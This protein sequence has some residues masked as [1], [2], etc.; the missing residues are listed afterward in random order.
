MIDGHHTLHSYWHNVYDSIQ[1]HI[2]LLIFFFFFLLIFS[3]FY[4]LF[5]ILNVLNLLFIPSLAFVV[6]RGR[7][8][9]RHPQQLDH[10]RQDHTEAAIVSL[11]LALTVW[12]TSINGTRL[13]GLRRTPHLRLRALH[14]V[15]QCRSKVARVFPLMEVDGDRQMMMMMMMMKHRISAFSKVML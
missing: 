10:H 9:H 13:L 2:N 14:E 15:A 3:Y 7:C 11:Y 4:Y 5:F 1:N 8:R 6:F 12:P